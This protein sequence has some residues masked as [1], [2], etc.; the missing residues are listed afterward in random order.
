MIEAIE[1]IEEIIDDM[2]TGVLDFT[3]NGECS[4]CGSCCSNYLPLSEKE[5]R[6]IRKYMKKHNITEKKQLMPTLYPM[7]D[8]T[9]PFL[10]NS[11]EKNKCTIYP[12]RPQIC[13]VFV[14]NQPPSQVN[15]N[16]ELFWRTR[17]PVNM[18]KTFFG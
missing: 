9:C 3:K 4:G 7:F 16:R 13:R 11:K 15:E 1:T 8:L 18:R 17:M 6:E 14:C 12:S 10:D 5:I 2:E